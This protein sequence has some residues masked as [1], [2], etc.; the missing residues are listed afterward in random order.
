MGGILRTRRILGGARVPRP[1]PGHRR[2]PGPQLQGAQAQPGIRTSTDT[3]THTSGGPVVAP[4]AV[5]GSY[6]WTG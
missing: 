5:Q 4:A 2:R 3:T 6:V 1:G